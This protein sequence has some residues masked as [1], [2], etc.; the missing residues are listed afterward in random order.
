LLRLLSS[1][2]LLVC[3]YFGLFAVVFLPDRSFDRSTR[4][5]LI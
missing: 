1:T 5:T 4:T 2:E 3:A